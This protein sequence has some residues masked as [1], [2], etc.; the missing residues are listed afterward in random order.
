MKRKKQLT[1]EEA[2]IAKLFE[3]RPGERTVQRPP[4]RGRIPPEVIRAAVAAVILERN[5]R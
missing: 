4:S 5:K 3:K 2:E 1:S